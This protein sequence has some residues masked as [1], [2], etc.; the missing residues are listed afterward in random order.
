MEARR[1]LK[2]ELYYHIEQRTWT[3][4]MTDAGL[5]IVLAIVTLGIYTYYIFYKLMDRRDKHLLRMANVVS[6]S[7]ELLKQKAEAAGKLN[8]ISEEL[9]QMEMIRARMYEQSRERGAALWLI[10]G[11]FTGIG[12]LIGYYFIMDDLA[13][14]DALESQFFT[15]MSSALAKL[16]VAG[17]SSVAYPSM[18]QRS[19]PIFL[20]LSFVT[21]GIYGFYWIYVLIND[22]NNHMSSQVEWEN[23]IYQALAA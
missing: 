18:P 17:G 3:D 9:N 7:M 4:W 13:T 12:I 10:I 21:C 2:D 1:N 11:I 14:H 20:V 23:F 8:L 5:A 19:Y 16:G 22:G 6:C 15:L